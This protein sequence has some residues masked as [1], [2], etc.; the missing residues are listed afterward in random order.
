MT[1]SKSPKFSVSELQELNTWTA[2][3]N[4]STPR[5]ESVEAEEAQHTLTV[6]E[7]ESMQKQAYDEAFQQGRMEG[8]AQGKLEGFEAGKLEGLAAGRQ[9]GYDENLHLLHKKAAELA[10]LMETLSQPFKN[11]DEAVEAELVKLALA[12]AGQ[13]VRREIKQESGEIIAVVREAIKI[14]PLAS[15]KITLTLHPE[16][17]ELVRS[18]LKLDESLPSW[19]LHE[20]PAITRGGCVVETEVST[21]DA[22]LEKRLAVVAATVLGG[23]R[24]QDTPL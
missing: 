7:I 19:R 3:V 13:I 12:V 6:E 9:Q 4:F 2:L 24:E 23:E 10:L 18:I 1:S 11:L 17:A 8:V 15:Q 22:T 16:D 20:S 21:I 14:L 5:S